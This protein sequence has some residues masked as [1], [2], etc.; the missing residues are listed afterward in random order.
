VLRTQEHTAGL[1]AW[2]ALLR[3]HAATTRGLGAQLAEYGLS[4][5]D[6]EALI[7]VSQ[8]DGGRMRRVDLADRLQLSPSGVTRLLEGLEA[9]GL[10]ERHVCTSD[11]RVAYAVI[12]A[13]GRER[14]AQASCSHLGA[15]RSVFEDRFDEAELV[16]LGELL[17]RLTA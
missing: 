4:L 3:A 13:A 1:T 14:L 8:A 6:Y 17:D 9:L 16:L 15:V 11:L 7:H 5:N 10:M 12:T 2:I